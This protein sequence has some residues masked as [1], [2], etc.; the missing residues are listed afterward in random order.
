MRFARSWVWSNARR[1]HDAGVGPKRVARPI[2]EL[3]R[4]RGWGVSVL[5]LNWL[6]AATFLAG[7]EGAR[8]PDDALS[9]R[10]TAAPIASQVDVGAQDLEGRWFL[11]Q[12]I[13]GAWPR[14]DRTVQIS[15]DGTGLVLREV[16]LQCNGAIQCETG[17]VETRYAPSREGRF[18][19]VDQGDTHAAYSGPAAL[20]VLWMDYDRRTFVVGDPGGTFAAI[21]DH[22]AQGGTDRIIAARDIL[23][24]FG[25]DLARVG[26]TSL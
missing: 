6:L 23:D 4:R 25:Y 5:R 19:R 16:V 15:A 1:L 11:R 24:W 9:F 3:A 2:F 26:E 17:A 18:V 8:A 12:H 20:W 13:S 22:R 14:G 21:F 10:D 7:C